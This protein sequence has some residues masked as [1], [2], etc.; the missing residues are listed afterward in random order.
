MIPTPRFLSLKGWMLSLSLC[1]GIAA[2]A[3]LADLPSPGAD[4]LFYVGPALSLA[5][6]GELRMELL[7]NQGFLSKDFLI[8][9]AFYQYLLGGWLWLMGISTLSLHLFTH[10]SYLL[11]AY[12]LSFLLARARVFGTATALWPVGG[13]LAVL[14]SLGSMGFRSEAL[15]FAVLAM[16]FGLS[17]TAGFWRCLLSWFLLGASLLISPNLLPYAA[18]LKLLQWILEDRHWRRRLREEAAPLLLALVGNILLMTWSIGGR[19]AE[20]HRAF[21]HHATRAVLPFFTALHAGLLRYLSGFRVM[22]VTVLSLSLCLCA[23]ILLWRKRR[24]RQASDTPVA[25]ALLTWLAAGLLS[26]G[27]TWIREELRLFTLVLAGLVAGLWL[28]GTQRT[29]VPGLIGLAALALAGLWM[30]DPLAPRWHSRLRPSP[31]HI[32]A[33][34]QAVAAEPGRR[35]L[36]DSHTART[37]FDYRL[38]DH[39]IDWFFSRP[40]PGLYP[41]SLAAL[42]PDET[43][44]ISGINLRLCDPTTAAFSPFLR[45][46]PLSLMRIVS[47]YDVVVIDGRKPADGQPGVKGSR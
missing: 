4:D 37:V 13:Y 44:I 14:G 22:P 39:A 45:L 2:L 21:M 33:A 28:A 31:A 1:L 5:K 29:R 30:R 36:I 6:H 32:A 19:W 18:L 47:D 11:G 16:A 26:I 27:M 20:F 38:P 23:F 25:C 7:A 8:Y 12:W 15:G 43:W 40:F 42:Q 35:F 3:I 17:L 9:P 46:G 10:L 41:T 34:Q 24:D